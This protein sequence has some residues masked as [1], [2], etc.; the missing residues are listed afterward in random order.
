[1]KRKISWPYQFKYTPN[2]KY[3]NCVCI[4]DDIRR[5]GEMTVVKE[6][7]T[8]MFNK[9]KRH[10]MVQNKRPNVHTV[11]IHVTS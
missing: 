10:Y 4:F 11:A 2:N 8:F 5:E 6:Y 9:G 3:S 1:M 7:D